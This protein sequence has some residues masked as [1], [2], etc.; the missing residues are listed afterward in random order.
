MLVSCCIG[1]GFFGAGSVLLVI[2]HT[3]LM[4]HPYR[5]LYLRLVRLWYCMDQLNANMT[6]RGVPG[7]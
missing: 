4:T 1:C 5:H 7:S 6:Q 3:I 2:A